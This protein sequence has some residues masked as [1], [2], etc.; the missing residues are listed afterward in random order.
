ML[1]LT[2][3]DSVLTL[4]GNKTALVDAAVLPTGP[5]GSGYSTLFVVDVVPPEDIPVGQSL[6]ITRVKG[7][8]NGLFFNVSCLLWTDYEYLTND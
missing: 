1:Q 7:V 5:G 8:E 3:L 4:P 6:N 2:L